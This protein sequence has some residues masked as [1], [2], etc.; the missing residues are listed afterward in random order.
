M[1]SR[2]RR[3]IL[4]GFTLVAALACGAVS[5]ADSTINVDETANFPAIRTFAIYESR[6]DTRKPEVDNRLFRQRMNN[7]I[8]A[9]LTA[10]G[11]KEVAENPDARVTFE[12]TDADYSLVERRPDVRMRDA[13]GQPGV[14]IPGGPTQNLFTEGTLTIDVFTA[15]NNTLVWRGTWRERAESGPTLS[16]ELSRDASKLL[17]KYPRL[18]K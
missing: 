17:E 3:A 9:A 18:K 12:F 6:L 16:R 5:A 14:V 10:K 15:A 7:S 4:S 2:K 1:N 11:L 13:P 8:R